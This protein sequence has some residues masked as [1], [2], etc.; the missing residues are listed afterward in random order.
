MKVKKFNERI[1]YKQYFTVQDLIDHLQK[2]DPEL[3][4]GKSGHFGELNPMDESD[5]YES[6]ASY[7]PKGHSYQSW[8]K[9]VQFPRQKILNINC[10]DIGPD[11]D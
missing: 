5:F 2:F 1:N 8:T 9:L 7:N 11:P 4:V 6:E 3:P 10:P